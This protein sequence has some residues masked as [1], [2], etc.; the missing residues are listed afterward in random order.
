VST[1]GWRGGDGPSPRGPRPLRAI[2]EEESGPEEAD[3][4]DVD[5]S[6]EANDFLFEEEAYRDME[7]FGAESGWF[8]AENKWDSDHL[9]LPQQVEGRSVAEMLMRTPEE[10]AEGLPRRTWTAA[11]GLPRVERVLT[12][13]E[14]LQGIREERV[15]RLL[16]FGGSRSVPDKSM[17]IRDHEVALRGT[18]FMVVFNDRTLAQAYVPEEDS[19][20]LY[21][22]ETHGVPCQMVAGAEG[23][24][25]VATMVTKQQS[26]AVVRRIDRLGMVAAVLAVPV[27]W[28]LSVLRQEW[29]GDVIDRANIRRWRDKEKRK[30]SEI[31]KLDALDLQVL[32]L[33]REGKSSREIC[34]EFTRGG[35]PVDEHFVEEMVEL[36]EQ[37]AL[38]EISAEDLRD[39][40]SDIDLSMLGFREEEGVGGGEGD[41]DEEDLEGRLKKLDKLKGEQA[42]GEKEG[43]ER[44]G[45]KTKKAAAAAQRREVSGAEKRLMTRIRNSRMR[46]IAARMRQRG[47]RFQQMEESTLTFDDV[48]GLPDATNAL[49][50]IVDFFHNPEYWRRA[51]A[52]VPKGVL[53]YGP[54][55]NGKTLM[56]RATAGESG[57]S[58]LSMNASEFIEMFQGVGAARVRE[59]F[60]VAKQLAPCIIF[61]DEIDAL[62]RKRGGVKGND[63][64]DQALNQ[65]LTEMDGFA[66]AEDVVVMGATNRIDVLDEALVR[67]GRFDRHI[68]VELPNVVAREAIFKVH[69]GKRPVASDVDYV[70]LAESSNGLSGAEISDVVNRAA[71]E[72][73]R[74]GTDEICAKHFS[75]ALTLQTDGEELNLKDETR[76]RL[77]IQAA[78]TALVMSLH[79]NAQRVKKVVVA[80]FENL[81]VPGVYGEE[82]NDL[83]ETKVLTA[84]Y[85]R[86]V[87]T[88][89]VAGY[90]GEG[91]LYGEAERSTINQPFLH[92]A[93]TVA[94]HLVLNMGA[95]PVADT[96]GGATDAQTTMRYPL[97]QQV[98]EKMSNA[99]TALGPRNAFH[100]NEEVSTDEY[101]TALLQVADE[102]HKGQDR[103]RTILGRNRAALDALVELFV[104]KR[105]LY[106]EEVR[107]VVREHVC[108]E[109]REAFLEKDNGALL[110]GR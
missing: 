44:P 20:V 12:Y 19:R 41:G 82:F 5:A 11:L 77:A 17:G 53:L 10:T 63:E 7:H 31:E 48:A 52:R 104:Q 94:S 33:V 101:N 34:S 74:E 45:G 29:K 100:L 38:P 30:L 3:E 73:A 98:M 22:A 35:Q 108:D 65:L 61:L 8:S 89:A 37:D 70:R 40:N 75:R 106:G 25:P 59:M 42:R 4:F 60:G 28:V 23:R 102:V 50:E 97:T 96:E 46:R 57:V 105:E 92:Y 9:R 95:S 110:T 78:S 6:L 66:T 49:K 103:A 55:G 18:P 14:V 88:V 69:S 83:L 64:R 56:A 13:G 32:Q 79:P 39:M 21:A 43:G 51:G 93:R 99:D 91:L 27:L 85:L 84:Q 68:K 2:F 72:A 86:T 1:P 36:R 58:F 76:R 26:D 90:E 24:A 109:D 81:K 80:A 16:F 67:P 87:L 62:G 54:P 47:L 107:D 15:D 71:F